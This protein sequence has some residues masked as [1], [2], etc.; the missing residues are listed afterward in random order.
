[1][2][3]IFNYPVNLV[4]KELLVDKTTNE[5][6]KFATD[7]YLS[8]GIE[9]NLNMDIKI[10]ESS[11][12]SISLKSRVHKS[13]ENQLLRQ[14]HKAEVFTPSWLCNVM[15]NKF[16]KLFFYTKPFNIEL[17]KSWRVINKKIPF[18]KNNE[19]KKYINLK[20]LEITC[21]ESPFIASRYDMA[22]GKSIEIHRRIGILDRKLRVINENAKT[23]NEWIKDTYNAFRSCYGYEFSGD[24]LLIARINLLLTFVENILFRW[25][26]KPTL[27]QLKTIADIITSN[28]WQMDGLNLKIPF[29]NLYPTITNHQTKQKLNF[30]DIITTNKTDT[31]FKSIKNKKMKFDFIIGNPPYQISRE[32][33][34]DM[35]VYDEFMDSC[36]EL[37]DKVCL[38]TPARFLFNAGATPKAWNKKILNDKHFKVLKYY[39]NSG[40]VFNNV[41][42]KGGVAIHYRNK[43]NDFGAIEIFLTFDELNSIK[44]KVFNVENFISLNTI[45]YPYSTY[46]L[47][48]ELWQDFPK[49]KERVEYIAKNRSKIPPQERK[50][51]LSNLR[52]ITTNIF[53][54]LPDLFFDEKPDDGNE[55]C[56]LIG[57]QNNKR[58][59]KYILKRY[60]NV[61]KNY[62]KYKVIVPKSNGSGALGE[63][64]STPLIGLPL[65]GYTQSF[66]GIGSFDT[67]FEVDAC[68]KYVKSKFARCMLGILKITQDNPPAKWKFVP[69]QDFTP[70]SDINWTK[71]IS[72]IDLQLYKKYNLNKDEINFIE[73]KVRAMDDE[74]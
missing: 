72:E 46:T 64:L 23:K 63:V 74:S 22:T 15:N 2:I 17:S 48:D 3:D 51:E 41:D 40:D 66:L 42:I 34:K 6:I 21:G 8:N 20:V 30:N 32:S 26:T 9:P 49:K 65:I 10:L 57:R 35:P 67:K 38:I 69:L 14:K 73:S 19:Y 7:D 44:N 28:F 24:S 53:D 39:P 60:I 68:L 27:T 11:L 59:K 55:Y 36:Y 54:L 45:M 52:I 29:T 16:D 62:D 31:L 61:A 58:V 25:Q 56:G 43:D 47:S 13:K 71:S 18:I 33:T 12:F 37:G 5:N 70:N 1:M 50:G 4:L